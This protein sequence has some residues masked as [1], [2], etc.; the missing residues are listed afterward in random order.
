MRT[1]TT[2]PFVFCLVMMETSAFAQQADFSGHWRLNE[3]MSQ[4]PFE[5]IY[6]SMGTEQLKGAGT[7]AYNSVNSGTL[8]RDS[9]RASTLRALLDYA[10]VLETVEIEQTEDELTIAVGAGDEFFSL[11]YLDGEKHARQLPAGLSIEAT[12]A[13]EGESI[14]ILQ[15]GENDAVL[16]EIYSLV[17]DGNQMAL[18][19]QLESKLTQIPVQ[20]RLVYDRVEA[21]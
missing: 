11:F 2:I 14:Q 20:F 4:N 15:V 1:A 5:K 6:V 13:W 16:K 10:E 17:G 21:D 3:K 19:F 12:A 9:D 8:L 7:S 18:L